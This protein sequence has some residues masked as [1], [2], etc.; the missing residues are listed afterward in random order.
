[1]RT[2]RMRRQVTIRTNTR[3]PDGMGGYTETPVDVPN[4]WARINPLEGNERIQ[5]MQ[6]GMQRP[7]E[8]TMRYRA[9]MTGASTLVYDGRTFDIKSVADTEERHRQLVILADEVNA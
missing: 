4:V 5:A 6:T 8:I 9:G 1:M 2:G 3:T 7:H